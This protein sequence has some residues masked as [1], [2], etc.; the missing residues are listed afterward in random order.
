MKSYWMTRHCEHTGYNNVVTSIIIPKKVS[1]P[2]SHMWLKIM[3][4][5]DACR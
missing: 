1:N 3:E 4:S 2:A 5:L